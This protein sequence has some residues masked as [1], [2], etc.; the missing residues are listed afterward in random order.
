MP[1]LPPD[2]APAPSRRGTQLSAPGRVF[3]SSN[4]APIHPPSDPQ[5]SATISKAKSKKVPDWLSKPQ[6]RTIAPGVIADYDSLL[7]TDP[8][9]VH[10]WQEKC[11]LNDNQITYLLQYFEQVSQLKGQ[12]RVRMIL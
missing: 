2:Q 10:S 12:G 9:E 7:L 8:Q 11:G 6:E 5:S 4:P 3:S 1:P